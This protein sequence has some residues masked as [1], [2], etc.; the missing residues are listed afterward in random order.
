V[1][2]ERITH[3]HLRRILQRDANLDVIVVVRDFAFDVV[4][5]ALQDLSRINAAPSPWLPASPPFADL[6]AAT[7]LSKDVSARR[8]GEALSAVSSLS[9]TLRALRV[10]FAF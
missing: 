6:V 9:S 3:A 4:I 7:A 8:I 5:A 10:L 2:V 1:F